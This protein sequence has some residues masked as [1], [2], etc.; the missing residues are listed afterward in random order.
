MHYLCT[1]LFY[2]FTI[3]PGTWIPLSHI[4]MRIAAFHTIR[5]RTFTST[6]TLSH[7][8][9]LA[10]I[11][12]DRQTWNMRW[13]AF[14]EVAATDGIIQYCIYLQ[15][16][17][18]LPISLRRPV[19]IFKLG[20]SVEYGFLG[21][22]IMCLRWFS[23]LCVNYSSSFPAT[24]MNI[25]PQDQIQKTWS[26]SGCGAPSKVCECSMSLLMFIL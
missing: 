9:A 5:S 10:E 17:A 14:A 7:T 20:I 12:Y 18:Y 13:S 21:V 4:Q 26:L 22:S 24:P 11:I 19:F 3:L 8:I 2:S 23:A 15:F 1:I 25:W 16:S 6:H